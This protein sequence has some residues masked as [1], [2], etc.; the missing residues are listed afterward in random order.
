[1]NERLVLPE[2]VSVDAVIQCAMDMEAA[3]ILAALEPI[4]AD[5]PQRIEV[6]VESAAVRSFTLGA[7]AGRHVLVAVSGIGLANSAAAT[8]RTLILVD[9]PIVIAAGTTGGLA[10]DIEVGQVAAGTSTIYGAA[11]ATAFGYAMGQIPQMPADYRSSDETVARVRVLADSF[12]APVRIGR[13]VST[14]SFV[15]E[16]IAEP[17]RAKFPD[18]IGADMETCAM[19]QIAWSCGADWVS[20][21]AVSDLCGPSADQDFHMDSA[22]A[23]AISARAVTAYLALA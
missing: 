20:L 15:T 21:R 23:A 13:V 1:M 16:P 18:A 8:A 10:R 19:A 14:D 9:A 5:G 7:L 17:V 3:P 11:D 12:D 6:S 22:A 2:R 4:G